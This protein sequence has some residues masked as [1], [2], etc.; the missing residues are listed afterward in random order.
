LLFEEY[1][2]QGGKKQAARYL[3]SGSRTK[4]GCFARNSPLK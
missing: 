1:S 3:L 2:A 4:K